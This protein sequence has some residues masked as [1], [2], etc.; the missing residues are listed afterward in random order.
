M[1]HQLFHIII[2]SLLV[3]ILMGCHTVPTNVTEKNELPDIYPDYIGVTIP[4]GIAPLNFSMTDDEIEAV[5][6]KA[7]G[8]KGGLLLSLIHI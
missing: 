3:T 2:L 1:K 7:E 8:S 4:V 6:V 5:D